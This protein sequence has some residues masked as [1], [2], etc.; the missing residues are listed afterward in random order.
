LPPQAAR[1][2]GPPRTRPRRCINRAKRTARRSGP[3]VV[4]NSNQPAARSKPI[5]VGAVTGR[6]DG[7]GSISKEVAMRPI[8]TIALLAL[9]L[10]ALAVAGR[11]S[12]PV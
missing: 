8:R 9:G 4:A 7:D 12:Q 11:Q 3:I 5:G 2:V 6:A 10:V 1:T